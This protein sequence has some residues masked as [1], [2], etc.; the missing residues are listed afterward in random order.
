MNDALRKYFRRI[1]A[2]GGRAK[3]PAKSAA[4]R[5]NAQKRWDMQRARMRKNGHRKGLVRG[6]LA[7]VAEIAKGT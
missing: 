2:V 1:G 7:Q 3:S 5:R 4:A 6:S